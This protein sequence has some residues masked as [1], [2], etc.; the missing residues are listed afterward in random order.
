MPAQLTRLG[1][2]QNSANL[3]IA[4]SAIILSKLILTT[5]KIF[6]ARPFCLVVVVSICQ[7]VF[8]EIAEFL[9]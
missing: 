2:D 8:L 4:W 5:E 1:I 3:S 7:K 6:I 9:K